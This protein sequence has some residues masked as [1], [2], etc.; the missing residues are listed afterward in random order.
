MW[1]TN[2]VYFDFSHVSIQFPCIHIFILLSNLFV[3]NARYMIKTIYTWKD[4]VTWLHIQ[5]GNDFDEYY[6][7]HHAKQLQFYVI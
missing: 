4:S 5:I 1:I 2:I 7:E 6:L 3:L